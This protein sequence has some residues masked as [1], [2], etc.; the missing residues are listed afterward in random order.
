MDDASPE[1]SDAPGSSRLS[2]SS[3]RVA[4]VL[5][6]GGLLV[7]LDTTVT[8]IAIPRLIHVFDTD[9]L[10]VQ[11]VTNAYVLALVAVIPVSAWLTARFGARRVYI[12]AVLVFTIASVLAG[13]AWNVESLIVF[14]AVQGLG[15][16]L[17]NPVGQAIALRSVGR[18]QR[19][20]IMSI[21]GIPVIV[22]P[23][24]GPPLA[25]FIIDAISWR[26]IFGINVP[27]GAALL[28]L[29]WRLLPRAHRKDGGPPP[30]DWT[31]L[32]LLPSGAVLFVLGLTLLGDVDAATRAWSLSFVV[33]GVMLSVI[34]V[35]RSLRKS[36]PLL[37]LTLMRDRVF[38]TSSIALFLFGAAYFG[39]F[40]VPILFV[41]AVRGDSALLTGVLG[42]PQIIA[43]GITLQFATRLVDRL[44]A[45]GLVVVG[46]SISLVGFAA[47]LAA[48][49]SDSSYAL[50]VA[51]GVVLGV[52]AGAT[53]M[54]TMTVALRG[55]RDRDTPDGTA[56][57]N[58]IQ[59]I[60]SSVG[61]AIVSAT[62]TMLVLVALPAG[63]NDVGQLF[64]LSG[65]DRAAYGNALANAVG[66]TYLAPVVLT[67]LAL[68]IAALGLRA[69]PARRG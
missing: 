46:L 58:L 33:V 6:L 24:L 48:V 53:L 52:G 37:K 25:G 16:G 45:R 4:S 40:T 20:R 17:L 9:L 49:S 10:T 36:Q 18:G 1:L 63:P 26:W 5:A 27:I 51:A 59:Q 22:G 31:G 57:L 12:A 69:R 19:G 39:S 2:A 44:P 38:A 28:V 14:R 21:L 23:L 7:I 60:A 15:G 65:S 47:L 41:Q 67:A 43:T 3:R 34:F 30:L 68:V 32:I 11:W 54:P 29:C 8:V 42:L 56:L 62:L 13:L 61:T 50:L 66:M 35:I 55:L 64:D